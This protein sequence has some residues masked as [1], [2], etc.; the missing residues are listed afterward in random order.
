MKKL[1]FLTF[2]GA[3][4]LL[5]IVIVMREYSVAASPQSET[6]F[7]S[8]MNEYE[9]TLSEYLNQISTLKENLKEEKIKTKMCEFQN[10]DIQ[11]KLND[12][13][14]EIP[15]ST[16][17]ERLELLLKYDPDLKN[18]LKSESYRYSLDE[19]AKQKVHELIDEKSYRRTVNNIHDWIKQNIQYEYDRKWHTAEE[20]WRTRKSNC[21][22]ISFLTCGMLREAGIP[23]KVVGNSE[24]VWTEYLYIDKEGRIIWSVWDQGNAGYSVFNY[25]I[26]DHDLD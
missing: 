14:G 23:C 3:M 16:F 4:I 5:S 9:K 26:Y 2:T 1:L 12:T 19:E 20:A 10:E 18:S 15:L 24:H 21:N 7:S 25:A 11:S 8:V 13:L 22:G 6:N 17:K